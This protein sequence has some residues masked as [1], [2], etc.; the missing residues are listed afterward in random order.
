MEQAFAS[1]PRADW[2]RILDEADIPC[3]PTQPLREF[4]SDPA[5]LQRGMVVEYEHPEVGRLRMMGQPL[6]FSESTAPDAGPPPVLG[7][8]TAEILREAGYGNGEIADLGRRG[9][10][11]GKDLPA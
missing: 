6:R 3:A 7:Q 2:L 1:K 5:V 8:H 10:V 4:M 9:V 11:A